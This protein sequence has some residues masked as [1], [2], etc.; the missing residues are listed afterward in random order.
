MKPY[1]KVYLI[2]L[3]FSGV[4]IGLPWLLKIID[5]TNGI[6]LLEWQ[7]ILSGLIALVLSAVYVLG[8]VKEWRPR[9]LIIIA[10]PAIYYCIILM[11]IGIRIASED[12]NGFNKLV[13]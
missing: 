1:F 7:G 11:Y 12:W 9:V 4:C 3:L 10:N 6:D 13:P 8:K 2:T 5:V